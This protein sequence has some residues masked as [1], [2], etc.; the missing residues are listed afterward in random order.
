MKTWE[1]INDALHDI[2]N[3][4]V[5]WGHEDAVQVE[6]AGYDGVRCRAEE[7]AILSNNMITQAKDYDKVSHSPSV[8][9]LIRHFDDYHAIMR[10]MRIP[11][12]QDGANADQKFMNEMGVCNGEVLGHMEQMKEYLIRKAQGYEHKSER[13]KGVRDACVAAAMRIQTQIELVNKIQENC[14]YAV[15]HGH[16]VPYG[17]SYENLL[18]QTDIYQEKDDTV[19]TVL[20]S[21]GLNTVYKV[22]DEER[23]TDRVFKEGH[24][25]VDQMQGGGSIYQRIRMKEAEAGKMATMNTAHR[26]VAVSLIDKLFGLN[27]VVDTSMARSRNGNQSS[28]M[29]LAEGQEVEQTYSYMNDKGRKYAELLKQIMVNEKY[30]TNGLGYEMS[31]EDKAEKAKNEKRQLVNINSAQFLEST[32]NLA[33]LDIIVGHVDR[34]VGNIMMTEK[35]VKGIDND[36]AFSLRDEFENFDG[37]MENLSWKQIREWKNSNDIEVRGEQAVLFFDKAF[38]AVT[39]E[40]KQK[41]IGVSES[42]IRGTL[43]GLIQEDEIEAC[44]NR[45]K[46][47][48]AYMRNVKIVDSFRDVDTESYSSQFNL[49]KE[50]SVNIM[51]QVRAAGGAAQLETDERIGQMFEAKSREEKVIRAYINRVGRPGA[52]MESE[53]V[54]VNMMRLL[55]D[56]VEADDT[57]DIFTALMDGTLEELCYQAMWITKTE[58]K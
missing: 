34:H 24:A 17:E 10:R 5:N 38:P 57:F 20:G 48:Q 44:V 45:T 26:D 18:T 27:A 2:G 19:S 29:D 52:D 16:G 4:F 32:Y 58:G 36:T 7:R 1:K 21:G 56:R 3:K 6:N 39:E 51:S 53:Q 55:K 9:S 31:K 50:F 15:R 46:K 47:L 33:A 23:N 42:A 22:R 8:K 41:I 49:G 43:K 13:Y 40:F 30:L 14:F 37:D 11:Q 54:T 25:N 12:R 35:G 28:L